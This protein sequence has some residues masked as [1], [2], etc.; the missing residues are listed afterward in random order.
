MPPYY[1]QRK[2]KIPK[3]L[4][5]IKVQNLPTT[6]LPSQIGFAAAQSFLFFPMQMIVGPL[7]MYPIIWFTCAWHINKY[8][9]IYIYINVCMYSF[10]CVYIYIY[11]LKICIIAGKERKRHWYIL[12]RLREITLMLAHGWTKTPVPFVYLRDKWRVTFNWRSLHF[13]I[14][15]LFHVLILSLWQI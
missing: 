14:H 1:T 6:M 9:Y 7:Q 2:A 8:I 13:L 5:T 4:Y 3:C 12:L 10:M 11:V 15:K